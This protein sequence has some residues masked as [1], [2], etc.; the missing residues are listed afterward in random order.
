MSKTSDRASAA[1]GVLAAGL[2]AAASAYWFVVRP[3]HL[4]WGASAE[5][6]AR[7]LPGDDLIPDAK[8]SSTHAITIHASPA[9]VWP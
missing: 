1:L 6:V 9:E 4:R 2:A 5:E 3:W 7:P 8:I